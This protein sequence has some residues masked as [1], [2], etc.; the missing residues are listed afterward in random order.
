MASKTR[1][2]RQKERR[3]HIESASVTEMNVDKNDGV[4]KKSSRPNKKLKHKHKIRLGHQTS[5]DIYDEFD[6]KQAALEQGS[7]C[8]TCRKF[9]RTQGFCVWCATKG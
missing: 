3:K 8:A 6:E 5:Y 9:I 1:K 2:R 7:R 4:V